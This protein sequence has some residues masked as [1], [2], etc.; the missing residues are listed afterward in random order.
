MESEGW[1][2]GSK[3]L[4]RKRIKR[5][6]GGQ[7]DGKRKPKWQKYRQTQERKKRKIGRNI[8]R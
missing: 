7:T 2:Q 6:R 8:E 1:N 5:K 4:K 3:G